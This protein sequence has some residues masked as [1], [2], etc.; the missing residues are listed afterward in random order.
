MILGK[1]NFMSSTPNVPPPAFA[2]PYHPPTAIPAQATVYR[3]TSGSLKVGENPGNIDWQLPIAKSRGACTAPGSNQ[4]R[5]C[6][7]H[8]VFTE[9]QDLVRAQQTSP[10][11]RKKS[12]SSVEATRGWIEAT[13]RNGDSHHD[14]WPDPLTY[15]PQ[16]VCEVERP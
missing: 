16:A 6:Y 7:S 15:I 1:V 8:S 11:A 5:D 10:W 3:L 14:W 4:K 2:L 12:I 9:L 13:P